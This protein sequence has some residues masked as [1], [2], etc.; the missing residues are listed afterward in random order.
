MCQVSITVGGF[1]QWMGGAR[2]QA[3]WGG[4]SEPNE[5]PWIRHEY[6]VWIEVLRLHVPGGYANDPFSDAV[7]SSTRINR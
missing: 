2:G 3:P 4:S 5:L 6:G 1:I 7:R